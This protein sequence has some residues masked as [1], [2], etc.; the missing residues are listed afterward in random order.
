MYN[1]FEPMYT[2]EPMY[3]TEYSYSYIKN[4]SNNKTTNT[5]TLGTQ[6]CQFCEQL[7]EDGKEIIVKMTI[8]GRAINIYGTYYKDKQAILN[9][10]IGIFQ[11]NPNDEWVYLNVDK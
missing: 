9:K 2:Y 7:P 5:N 6:F 11:I 10:Y 4:N 1:K 8:D 3:F